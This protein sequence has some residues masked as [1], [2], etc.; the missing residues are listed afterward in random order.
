MDNKEK[1]ILL[2]LEELII[3]VS[4]IVLILAALLPWGSTENVTVLG[5]FGDDTFI[6]IGVGILAILFLLT[7]KIPTWI[8]LLLGLIALGT[9][10]NDYI[11]LSNVFEGNGGSVG[12]GMYLTLLGG[13][14]VVVGSI[15]DMLRSAK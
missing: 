13:L 6:T 3:G 10:I 1:K 12:S 9:G 11:A 2:K 15:L 5:I 7:K 4:A 14:G 8:S